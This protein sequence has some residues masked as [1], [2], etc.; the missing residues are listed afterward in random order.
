MLKTAL[1]TFAIVIGLVYAPIVV[2][3][4]GIVYL[5]LNWKAPQRR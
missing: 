2:V 1:W 3:V 4:A 5:A